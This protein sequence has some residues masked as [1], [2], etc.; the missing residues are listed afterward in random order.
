MLPPE[1]V[2]EKV[3]YD[4]DDLDRLGLIGM[5][6]GMMVGAAARSMEDIIE[7][8]LEKRKLDYERLHFQAS[9]EL[10]RKLYEERDVAYENLSKAKTY[11]EACRLHL[12]GIEPKPEYY[13]T[14][15]QLLEDTEQAIQDRFDNHW[16]EAEQSRILKDWENAAQ[17]LKI[18]LK[19]IPDR[20]DER[21][22][23]A[24]EKLIVVERYLKR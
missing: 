13:A 17:H 23:K 24:S 7:N 10:G 3:V 12:K 19:L 6:R 8:R 18:I 11:L 15:V 20:E 16:Y 2:A 4:A 22:E 14:A 9:R 21:Y 1:T 5:L